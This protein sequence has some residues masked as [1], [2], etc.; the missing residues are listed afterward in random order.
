MLTSPEERM[1]CVTHRYKPENYTTVSAHFSSIDKALI[2][3]SLSFNC[4]CDLSAFAFVNPTESSTKIN[5]CKA[6]W[7]APLTGTDSRAG[8]IV[9]ETSHLVANTEDYAYGHE[10]ASAL[11]T[12]DPSRAIYNADNHEYFVENVSNDR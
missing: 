4:E 12:S 5:L 1:D 3:D 11:A 9:H 10:A 8:T 2:K 7:A 6:F